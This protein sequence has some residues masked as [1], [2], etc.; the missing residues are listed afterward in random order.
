LAVVYEAPHAADAALYPA[1]CRHLQPR[2]REL[3]GRVLDVGFGG[4]WWV[5]GA[6]LRDCDINEE[7]FEGLPAR[8]RRLDP[9]HLHSHH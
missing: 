5:L 9:H 8:L 2:W 4:R 6:R 7:E 3:P 1:Q